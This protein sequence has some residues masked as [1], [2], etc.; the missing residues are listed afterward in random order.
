MVPFLRRTPCAKSCV[1]LPFV[2]GNASFCSSSAWNR[3]LLSVHSWLVLV[4]ILPC[5]TMWSLCPLLPSHLQSWSYM[6]AG[7]IYFQSLPSL[8]LCRALEMAGLTSSM[9]PLLWRWSGFHAL[10][11][12][13]SNE[14]QPG[15]SAAV[16]QEPCRL[17]IELLFGVL[18]YFANQ[19]LL[20]LVCVV[21]QETFQLFHPVFQTPSDLDRRLRR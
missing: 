17:I 11:Y 15:S 8:G 19:K 2:S 5:G 3:V 21:P 16:K 10:P 7:Q 4:I 20:S 1:W 18:I 12:V 14:I 9:L 6:A 13:L